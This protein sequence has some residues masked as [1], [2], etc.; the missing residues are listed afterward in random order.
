MHKFTLK[1]LYLVLL[2]STFVTSQEISTKIDALM[3]TLHDN[4]LFDGTALVAEGENIIYTGSFGLADRDWNVPIAID[5]KF[6]VAS[7]SKQFTSMMILQMV[8]QGKIKLD[9]KVTTYLPSFPA[10]KGDKIT[11]HHLLSHSSG[12]AHYAGFEA[13]GVNIDEY[14]RLNK[15]VE[16]YVKTIGKM[17]L[18]S[19]P[20][21][22]YSYSSMGY[23]MLGLII[24]K[25]SGLPY[26]EAL[27]QFICRPLKLENTGFELSETIVPNLA[28]GYQY[29]FKAL[30]NGDPHTGYYKEPYRDQTNKFSTGGIHSTVEDLFRWTQALRAYKLLPEEY[31]KKMFQKQSS[32]YGYGWNIQEMELG[33]KKI[34]IIDHTGGLSGY[35]SIVSM[36]NDGEKTIVLLSNLDLTQV[37]TTVK[38]ILNLMDGLNLD[39][40]LNGPMLVAEKMVFNGIDE[41][42]QF[43]NSIINQKDKYTFSE[44][45]YNNF[46]Y[47]LVGV[48]NFN[49]AIKMFELGIKTHP[50][51]ANL[52]DSLGEAHMN[53][54][55]NAKA[56]ELYKQALKIANKNPEK[57]ENVIKS[58]T[59]MLKNL[60]EK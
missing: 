44:G 42:I 39:P 41:G 55:N 29:L 32:N 57:N 48:G 27:Q 16:E 36:I 11:I 40:I 2:I 3:Q 35:R 47:Q 52:Y 25:I 54:G 31:T 37:S 43:H 12:L 24:E 51:A 38:Q 4:H 50:K 30:P 59:L 58:A 6:L 18:Q 34:N 53:N 46:G 33:D 19:E 13:I 21:A 15:S 56:I 28:K 22:Q 5:T 23:I 26:G 14:G 45:S 49:A 20:G 9:E 7:V 17:N 10:D 60:G 8:V 1:L